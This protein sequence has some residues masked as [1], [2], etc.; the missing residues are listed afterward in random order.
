MIKPEARGEPS[1]GPW[2][3]LA[4]APPV[5]LAALTSQGW[6]ARKGPWGCGPALSHAGLC[7]GRAPVVAAWG[8]ALEG[9]LPGSGPGVGQEVALLT[10]AQGRGGARPPPPQRLPGRTCGHCPAGAGGRR[11]AR[12]CLLVSSGT[13]HVAV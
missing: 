8:S 6:A 10:E 9:Q 2:A 7:P 12:S 13:K 1:G 4:C 11:R 3:A 5:T